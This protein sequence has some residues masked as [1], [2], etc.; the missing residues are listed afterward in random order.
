MVSKE[1]KESM[2]AHKKQI[3]KEDKEFKKKHGY[4]APKYYNIEV[5]R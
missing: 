5:D 3:R 2:K 1:Y 4:P